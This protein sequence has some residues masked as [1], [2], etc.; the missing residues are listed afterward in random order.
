MPDTDVN[1]AENEMCSSPSQ[2]S[3]EDSDSDNSVAEEASA[4]ANG[5]LMPV[6]AGVVTAACD[7]IVL[8]LE[9]IVTS[10]DAQI[11][12]AHNTV[13]ETVTAM[14]ATVDGLKL[15]MSTMFD[16]LLAT[17]RDKFREQDQALVAKLQEQGRVH[18]AKVR[19]LEQTLESQNQDLKAL[20]AE[21]LERKKDMRLLLES[22]EGNAD[23]IP[24]T[25]SIKRLRSETNPGPSTTHLR[26]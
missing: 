3:T 26:D 24:S 17:I 11:D 13:Q 1:M 12:A 19:G 14:D 6:V 22:R 5:W 10:M 9:R 18:A 8:R 15:F 20:K 23:L 4:S 7:N 25:R 21:V 16:E 2:S